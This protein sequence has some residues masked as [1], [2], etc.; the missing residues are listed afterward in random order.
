MSLMRLAKAKKKTVGS[1]QTLK[2]VQLGTARVV[3][4]AQ[5]AE[6]HVVT[7]VIQAC[8]L[9]NI[10]V[11]RI[12]DMQSLGKTCGIE[13]GCAVASIVEEEEI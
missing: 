8:G 12:S 9:K 11:I 2:A 3:Y 13:V 7:P 1:K 6:E 5:D 10:P 4:I